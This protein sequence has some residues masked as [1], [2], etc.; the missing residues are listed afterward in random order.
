MI[1]VAIAASSQKAT[2]LGAAVGPEPVWPASA[3]NAG[4][5]AALI[6]NS[7]QTEATAIA[8]NMA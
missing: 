1:R 7:A 4:A 2:S 8:T 6:S 3:S 5:C